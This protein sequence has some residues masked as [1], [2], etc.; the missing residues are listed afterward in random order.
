MT[1]EGLLSLRGKRIV[2]DKNTKKKM[3][4]EKIDFIPSLKEERAICRPVLTPKQKSQKKQRQIF[5][6]KFED[7]ELAK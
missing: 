5:I 2:R 6:K 3:E 4:F 7:L 1:K